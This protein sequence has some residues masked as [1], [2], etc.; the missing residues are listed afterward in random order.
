MTEGEV[1]EVLQFEEE[2]GQEGWWLVRSP[3]GKEGFV[4]DNFVELLPG[5]IY[6]SSTSGSS[7]I[8]SGGGSSSS[9]GGGGSSSSFF[10]SCSIPQPVLLDNSI[11]AN[12][13]ILYLPTSH[14]KSV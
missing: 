2:T 13:H 11:T 7:S 10:N 8:S 4:P 12:M 3:G 1:L 5:S 14:F 6:S 9:S